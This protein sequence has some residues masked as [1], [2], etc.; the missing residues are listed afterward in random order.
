M[1]S[2]EKGRIWYGGIYEKKTVLISVITLVCILALTCCIFH[3]VTNI[4]NGNIQ[5]Y[6][7]SEKESEQLT[8]LTEIVQKLDKK[9]LIIQVVGDRCQVA[10]KDGK[11]V[12]ASTKELTK[13]EINYIT[14]L[15][16][17][18]TVRN[19]ISLEQMYK[20]IDELMI[21]HPGKD[22]YRVD[23]ENDI[24]LEV[25][26]LVEE[27]DVAEDA[28]PQ[29]GR[30]PN[31]IELLNGIKQVTDGTYEYM[32][33]WRLYTGVYYIQNSFSVSAKFSN[34]CHNVEILNIHSASG[35]AG[36]IN[37]DE[38]ENSVQIDSWNANSLDLWCEAESTLF[39][40]IPKVI[41]VSLNDPYSSE[42]HMSHSW[43]V[44]NIIRIVGNEFYPYSAYYNG[45]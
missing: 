9:G 20:D 28:A 37:L 13:K 12:T 29:N 1:G 30:Y 22:T 44:F 26:I 33:Q 5:M 35:C 6:G 2:L 16:Q 40:S 10:D 39:A 7:L 4:N 25:Q 21:L 24:W 34:Q 45:K 38:K 3:F 14:D 42:N 27:I 23:Y 11:I 15:L 36:L 17:R 41:Q 18:Y 43:T 31:E 8:N 19:K 32:Y